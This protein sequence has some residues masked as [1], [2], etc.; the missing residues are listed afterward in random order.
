M[1]STSVYGLELLVFVRCGRKSPSNRPQ[2]IGEQRKTTERDFARA[3]LGREPKQERGGGEEGRKPMD[4][5]N[6]PS[7]ANGARDWLEQ[8]NI[9]DMCRS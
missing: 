1:N 6:L 5:E 8:S 4:F 3:V 7:P 2:W 9:I